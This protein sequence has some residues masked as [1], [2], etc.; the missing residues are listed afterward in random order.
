MIGD[1]S[2]RRAER[3]TLE[4]GT[5]PQDSTPALLYPAAGGAVYLGLY[6]TREETRLQVY[7]VTGQGR[8]AELLL[9]QV[10]PGEE[11]PAQMAGTYLSDFAEVDSVVTFAVIQGD[12]ARFYQRTSAS[13]GLEEGR[14]VHQAGLRTALA[15]PDGA[16]ALASGDQLVR[17]DGLAISLEAG[18]RIT[19]LTQ[20]GNGVYYVDGAKLQVCFADFADWRPYALLDLEKEAYDLDRCTD[21]W[22]TR[23]G[24]TL[25][26][27]DGQRLLLDRGSTVSDLSGMLYR[28]PVQCG[29]ILAGLALGVL[30]LAVL[31]WFLLWEQ[32]RMRLPMLVRWGALTVAAAALGTGI[33]VRGTVL[34]PAR[35]PRS[36]RPAASWGGSPPRPFRLWSWTTAACPGGWAEA[37]PRRGESST[38]TPP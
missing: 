11:L 32:R 19:Q 21:L 1:Q 2:G 4:D 9:D 15:L 17:T 24:D 33:L 37:W 31:L 29:L 16:L 30:A 26:L 38:G 5:V 27:M 12:S 13:S 18:E 10:C 34:R 6:D 25:L 23:D 36:G 28:S 7:R 14:T 20:A 8:E 35:P 22:V 3:W